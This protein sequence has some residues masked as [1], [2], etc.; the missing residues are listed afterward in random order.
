MS[1]Q[2]GEQS[3]RR[4]RWSLWG[5]LLVGLFL[6]HDAFM[7][8]EAV[9]I[10]HAGAMPVAHIVG[11]PHQPHDGGTW[12]RSAPEPEHP[13]NCG[14]GQSATPRTSDDAA[15]AD[16]ALTPLSSAL[17]GCLLTDRH[18]PPA[19]GEE[20]HWPPGTQRALFQVYR[21]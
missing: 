19:A 8:A 11:L 6:S 1:E 15:S 9:A 13:V 12:Q 20:P 16:G 10:P 3:I 7:A 18:L 17:F 14:I 21:L 2:Q 5:L 4:R